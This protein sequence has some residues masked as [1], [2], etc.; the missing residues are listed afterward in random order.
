MKVMRLLKKLRNF[1]VIVASALLSSAWGF[2]IAIPIA[3]FFSL[4]ETQSFL[5]VAAPLFSILFLWGLIYLPKALRR[6]GMIE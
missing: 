5:Y 3:Q 2:I 6:A 4:E 1:V